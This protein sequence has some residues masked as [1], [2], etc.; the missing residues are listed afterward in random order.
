MI[1]QIRL[2]RIAQVWKSLLSNA[3]PDNVMWFLNG[4]GA[5]PFMSKKIAQVSMYCDK[6]QH[7]RP[8]ILRE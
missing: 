6:E 8:M 1:H 7:H 4:T 2:D 5:R 3:K